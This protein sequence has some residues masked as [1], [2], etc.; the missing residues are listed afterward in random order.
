M[1]KLLKFQ[2][3]FTES[4]NGRYTTDNKT[5]LMRAVFTT[6]LQYNRVAVRHQKSLQ[7]EAGI[8][9]LNALIRAKQDNHVEQCLNSLYGE[10]F[11]KR[12]KQSPERQLFV[13]IVNDLNQLQGSMFSF[14]QNQ[15]ISSLSFSELWFLLWENM[16]ENV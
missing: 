12:T 14:T 7:Y 13:R 11:S 10:K 3:K 2:L 6:E 9:Y 16:T 4:S 15:T 8:R 5:T 1:L